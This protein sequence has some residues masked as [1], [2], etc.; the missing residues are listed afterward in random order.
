MTDSKS[1]TQGAFDVG[2][3]PHGLSAD[4]PRTH[5]ETHSEVASHSLADE[6]EGLPHREHRPQRRE[7]VASGGPAPEIYRS[8]SIRRACRRVKEAASKLFKGSHVLRMDDCEFLHVVYAIERERN[9]TH[10][11]IR[12][13]LA[14]VGDLRGTD[15]L[16]EKLQVLRAVRMRNPGRVR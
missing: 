3:S 10:K 4:R 7:D 5:Q 6:V 14:E 12:K 11:A 9:K 13:G 8:V 1:Q 2:T 16:W 15:S